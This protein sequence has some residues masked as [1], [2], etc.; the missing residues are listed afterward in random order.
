MKKLSKTMQIKNVLI[1]YVKN[2]SREYTISLLIYIIGLFI[3]VLFV[4]N[5]SQDKLQVVTKYILDFIENFKSSQ[6]EINIISMILNSIS[7]DLKMVI[8]LWL[9]GTTIIGLP[10][11][12][13]LIMFRGFCLGYTI[14]SISITLGIKKSILFCIMGLT[15]QNIIYIP[16]L[17][18]I[19]VSCI[20]I[21]KSI[22]DK[23]RRENLKNVIMR[24]TLILL[25]ALIIL[26]IASLIECTISLQ[27][28]KLYMKM[29]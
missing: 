26:I 24:H 28:L 19:G 10:I 4:N 20:K 3:G 16:A 8:I 2:N 14:S 29:F 12:F 5:L 1:N 17:L 7:N 9:A 21:Y 23:K 15:S 27:F 13:G 6:N 25:I 18:T 11:V 22:I